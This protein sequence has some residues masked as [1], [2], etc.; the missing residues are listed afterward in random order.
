[1]DLNST[2]Q[3][4]NNIAGLVSIKQLIKDATYMMEKCPESFIVGDFVIDVDSHVREVEALASNEFFA[5]RW[6]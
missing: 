2:L 4:I 1:M 3:L 5:R 6:W